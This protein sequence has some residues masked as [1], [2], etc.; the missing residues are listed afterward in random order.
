MAKLYALTAGAARQTTSAPHQNSPLR[1]EYGSDQF[2]ICHF[3]E[4]FNMADIHLLGIYRVIRT[5]GQNPGG[6]AARRLR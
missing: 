5:P 1:S 3:G 4:H 2:H 6:R